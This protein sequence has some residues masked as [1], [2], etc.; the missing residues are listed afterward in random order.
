MKSSKSQIH[1]IPSQ[2]AAHAE[3]GPSSR[4]CSY[5]PPSCCL[6]GQVIKVSVKPLA[7]IGMRRLNTYQ[8]G[9]A[10]TAIT[11]PSRGPE[12][13]GLPRSISFEC[14]IRTEMTLCQCL[15]TLL[16]IAVGVI[17]L[18]FCSAFLM[19][20]FLIKVFAHFVEH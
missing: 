19:I 7:L 5:Y 9:W 8:R 2:Q 10:S 6:V 14:S 13:N 16:H 17:V 12:G 18:W 11:R 4:P 3:L 15:G 1:T 20:V